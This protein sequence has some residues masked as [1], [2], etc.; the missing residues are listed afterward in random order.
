MREQYASALMNRL[1]LAEIYLEDG[2]WHTALGLI[3]EAMEIASPYLA[4][5]EDHGDVSTHI[6]ERV[7]I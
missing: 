4:D 5:S 2:A 1:G 6:L 3:R 7:N